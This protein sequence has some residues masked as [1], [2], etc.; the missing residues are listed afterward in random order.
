MFAFTSVISNEFFPL[1]VFP[2]L[3]PTKVHS[4]LTSSGTGRD[5][6]H[7]NSW[8][9]SHWYYVWKR[10]LNSLLLCVSVMQVCGGGALESRAEQ[11]AAFN[12]QEFMGRLYNWEPFTEGED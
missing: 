10:M 11:C 1:G 2:C 6:S 5:N 12:T 3:L 9:I 8:V 7:V 4:S